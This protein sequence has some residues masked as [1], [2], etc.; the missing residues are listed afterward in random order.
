MFKP[1]EYYL[2][3]RKDFERQFN[4]L[5]E[6]LIENKMKFSY[7]SKKSVESLQ[8]IR[9]APNRRYDLNTID[10]VSRTMG[11]AAV[12]LPSMETKNIQDEKQ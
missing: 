8:K 5:S 11:N 2:N 12:N 7:Q 9:M 6:L 3:C 10:E 4:C 1:N